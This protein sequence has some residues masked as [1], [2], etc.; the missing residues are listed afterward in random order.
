MNLHATALGTFAVLVVQVCSP[1]VGQICPVPLEGAQRLVLVTAATMA[2]SAATL[3]LFERASA[4]APWRSAHPAEPAVIGRAGLAWGYPFRDLARGDE[5]IKT[6][7]D[8]RTPA[9]IYLI[10]RSFGFTPSHRPAYL[11]LRARDSVCIDDPSSPAYNTITRRSVVGPDVHGEDMRDIDLY[12]RGLVIE[13][14]TD[15]AAPAGSCIFIHVW[16]AAG[17]VTTGCVALPEPRVVAVQDFA[18]HGAV[19]AIVP[20]GMLDRFSGCL[21]E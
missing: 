20:R 13:Y 8:Q 19:I 4:H 18:E 12:R 9:G 15:A 7:G 3:Q 11:Q 14:P 17:Q 10:G 16:R 1:A 21:P 2:S 6:E 5:P